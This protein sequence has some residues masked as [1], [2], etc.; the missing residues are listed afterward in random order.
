MTAI[1][2]MIF[3][4]CIFLNNNLRMLID[5]S[6]NFVPKGPVNNK[7]SLQLSHFMEYTIYAT[8]DDAPICI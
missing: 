8:L 6:L 1:L 7:A 4:K 2:Q 5:I 3:S